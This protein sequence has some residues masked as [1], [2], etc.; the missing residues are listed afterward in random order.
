MTAHRFEFY[1][2]KE[3]SWF[4]TGTVVMLLDDYRPRLNAGLFRGFRD[5]K[6]DEEICDFDEFYIRR[7]KGDVNIVHP[8]KVPD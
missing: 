2:A 5:K 7:I 4:D 1:V 8:N 6:A 3:V